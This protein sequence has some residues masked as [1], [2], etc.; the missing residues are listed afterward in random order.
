MRIAPNKMAALSIAAAVLL[1]TPVLAGNSDEPV[2]VTRP[3]TFVTKAET[4]NF[5]AA[6]G[7]RLAATSPRNDWLIVELAM[8][9]RGGKT[10]TIRRED[11]QLIA[12]DGTVVPLAD[13]KAFGAS[14]NELRS[15]L[16]R[17]VVTRDPLGYFPPLRRY[18]DIQFFTEPGRKVVFDLVQVDHLRVCDGI[19][20]FQLPKGFVAGT[21]TLVM[22]QPEGA[23]HMPLIL[24]NA[25]AE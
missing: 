23:I 17:M 12:P 15:Y 20:A 5:V 8:S 9:A 22:Q 6:V 1:A 16:R 11:V 7:Y 14:Y 25:K 4:D 13:Q 18:C 3:G 24:G 10:A 2:K 21:W 19:L